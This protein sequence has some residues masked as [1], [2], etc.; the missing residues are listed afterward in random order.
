[1]RSPA[2]AVPGGAAF[3]KSVARSG[4][5]VLCRRT[6]GGAHQT[7]AKIGE[8][9]VVSRTSAMQYKGVHKP[10]REIARELEVDAIVK[11]TVL[12]AGRRV[13]ITA[14]LIDAPKETH[15]WAESYERDL[16]D[17]LTLQA[18]VAQAIAREIRVKLTPV[19]QA[20]FAEVRA[21]DP[22]AYEA[23]LRGRY[24]WNRRSSEGL[25]KAIE[26][27]RQAVASDP[28]Y[29]SANAG[30][31]DCFSSLGFWSFVAPDEGCGKAKG[32]AQKALEMDR[33]LAEAHAS[34]AFPTIFYDYDFVTAEESSIGLLN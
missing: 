5:G 10:L 6:D 9:R 28:T 4:A 15:L 12:R 13:R 2:D 31:A 29:A 23:Y 25:G 24:H 30:L 11:G 22:D 20:R 17:V 8:L 14:Q 34:L 32:I 33:S 3:R 1:M 18:E 21:V 16:R 19:D 26:N 27:F 7:L